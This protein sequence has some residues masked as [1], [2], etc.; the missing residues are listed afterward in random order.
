MERAKWIEHKGKRIFE[1]DCTNASL[2]EMNQVIEECIKEVRSQPEQSVFT[3]IV[4]G[5]TAFSGETIGNLKE[6][7]RDNA[8]YVKASAIV[9]VTGLYKVVFNAVALFSKRRFDLFDNVEE[10][11][12]YLAKQE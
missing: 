2:E 5:G 8:P 7:A 9:G 4:A 11:R 6:L 10:A 1:M 3:L 12:D